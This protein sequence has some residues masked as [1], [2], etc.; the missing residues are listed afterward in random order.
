MDDRVLIVF[1]CAYDG[2]GVVVV[3]VMVIKVEVV[4]LVMV[5]G[6]QDGGRIWW[7]QATKSSC[8]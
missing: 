8:W 7:Q 2:G 1:D 3:F 6:C 5:G 4:V